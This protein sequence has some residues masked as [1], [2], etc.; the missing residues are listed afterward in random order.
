MTA[1]PAGDRA[2]LVGTSVAVLGAGGFIGRHI[3]A[4][5]LARGARVVAVTRQPVAPGDAEV[6]T[7]PDLATVPAAALATLIGDLR[8]RVLVNASG[9]VWR[10]G[11][12]PMEAVNAGLVSRLTTALTRLGDPPR[13]IQ[14]GSAYEYGPVPPGVLVPEHHPARPTADY[15]RTKLLGTRAVLRAART[16][17]LDGTVLRLAVVIG[18]DTP[19]ASLLGV[20]TGH[21]LGTAAALAAGTEPEVLVLAPLREQRDLID[22][23]D[24]AAAVVAAARA[25]GDLIRGQVVNVGSGSVVPVRAVVERLVQLAGIPARFSYTGGPGQ[26]ARS[27]TP[28]LGLNIGKAATVLEWQPARSLDASLRDLLVARVDRGRRPPVV[29]PNPSSGFSVANNRGR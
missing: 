20:V 3:C 17:G 1:P 29:E 21:L 27:E 19:P 16:A 24:V 5:L 7:G 2:G 26:A 15:G 18:P 22:V 11:P 6:V 14:L 8:V 10:A 13:L 28:W 25:P 12:A 4:A 23:H 9:A